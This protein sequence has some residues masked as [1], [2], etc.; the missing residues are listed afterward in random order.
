MQRLP[1][2]WIQDGYD[3][4]VVYTPPHQ[5]GAHALH[6]AFLAFLTAQGIP[7]DRPIIFEDP[8][9]P[10][11]TSMWQVLL[12]NPDPAAIERDLGRCVAWMM[13]NRGGLSVMI[14]PNTTAESGF[15]GHLADHR[16]YRLWMGEPQVLKLDIFR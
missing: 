4:H 12:K 15:G 1:S 2:D 3:I 6:H 9:G 13:I 10:W 16:D 11:P 5:A 14:H 8:V 7:Y